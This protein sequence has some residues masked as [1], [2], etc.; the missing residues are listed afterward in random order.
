MFLLEGNEQ[1]HIILET[2]DTEEASYLWHFPK[3]VANLPLQL[4]EIDVHLDTIRK[5]GRQMYL[6][7]PPE[8][9]SRL[10][11]DYTDDQ[12]GFIIWKDSLLEQLM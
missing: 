11:H 5:R 10:L 6:Q 8:N 4:K 9:F 12:K 3:V 1:F 2:L 7:A